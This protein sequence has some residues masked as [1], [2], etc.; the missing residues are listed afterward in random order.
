MSH[1]DELYYYAHFCCAPY[2]FVGLLSVWLLTQ[3]NSIVCESHVWFP[4]NATDATRSIRNARTARID[5]AAHRCVI[6]RRLGH[7]REVAS[8]A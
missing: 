6:A 7:L 3:N 2:H 5:T 1:R 4:P 8:L